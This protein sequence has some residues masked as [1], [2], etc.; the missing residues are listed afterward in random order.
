VVGTVRVAESTGPLEERIGRSR[1]V[2]VAVGLFVIAVTMLV[3]ALL[4][5]SLARPL[6]NLRE[7]PGAS[8]EEISRTGPKR[9][10]PARW[11]RWQSR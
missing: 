3:A 10:V 2:L 6:R 7:L 11:P 9:K 8:A 1:L 4:A 5:A